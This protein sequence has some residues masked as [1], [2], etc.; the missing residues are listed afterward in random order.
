MKPRIT[1][2]ETTL[3]DDSPLKLEEHDGRMSLVIHGQQICGS[4]TR[5]AWARS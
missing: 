2:A 3:P 5:S 4:A 1:L